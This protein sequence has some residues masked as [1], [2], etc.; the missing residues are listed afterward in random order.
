SEELGELAAADADLSLVEAFA[1]KSRRPFFLGITAMRRA[2]RAILEGRYED[3]QRQSEAMLSVGGDSPDFVAAFGVQIVLVR[4]D[5]GRLDELESLIFEQIASSP[6]I[7]AW[8]VAGLLIHS[9]A[10]RRHRAKEGLRQLVGDEVAAIPRDWLWP[11]AVAGL[12]D[13]CVNLND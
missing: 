5:E 6:R 2:G 3:A 10:G 7:P 13:V 4:R 8:K 1:V 9:A 12:A 11:L